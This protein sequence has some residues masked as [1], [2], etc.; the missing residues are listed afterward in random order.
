MKCGFYGRGGK[1]DAGKYLLSSLQETPVVL[2][3]YQL[4][5]NITPSTVVLSDP[6]YDNGHGERM[7][8]NSIGAAWDYQPDDLDDDFFSF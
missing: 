1:D 8:I 5:E 2:H 6:D 4:T 3:D 7:F